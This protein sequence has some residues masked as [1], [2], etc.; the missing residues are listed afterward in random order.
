MGVEPFLIA[1]ALEC[2][3]GQRLVRMLCANCKQRTIIPAEVLQ[4]AGYRARLDVE[5]YGPAG[6]SRCGGTGY[7]GRVGLYEVMTMSQEIQELALERSPAE[8]IRDVAVRQGMTRMSD[9]GLSKVCQGRTSIAE[10][11]RVLGG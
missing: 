9:D 3:V 8:A 1:S 11:A 6:C 4:Q 5:A 10:V 7:R 2:I